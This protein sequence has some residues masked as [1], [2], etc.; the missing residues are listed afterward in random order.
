MRKERKKEEDRN[1]R[2]KPNSAR[3]LAVS[4]AG[5]LYI[6]FWGLLP[7][8]EILPGVQTSLYVEVLRSPILAASLCGTQAA[9]I[10]QTLWHPTRN[11]ITELLQRAPPMFG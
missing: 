3:C 4:W 11:G 1:H 2:A 9:G 6:H 5:T 8:D 10:S 7:P